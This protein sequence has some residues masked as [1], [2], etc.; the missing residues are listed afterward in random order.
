MLDHAEQLA[1]LLAPVDCIAV[2]G[3]IATRITLGDVKLAGTLRVALVWYRE[4]AA[5][6]NAPRHLCSH[7]LA[8]FATTAASVRQ[9]WMHK[10]ITPKMHVLTCHA[11]PFAVRWGSI[12]L[13]TEQAVESAHAVWNNLFSLNRNIQNDLARLRNVVERFVLHSSRPEVERLKRICPQCTRPI[14][15]RCHPHCDCAKER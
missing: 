6:Y 10:S 4:L 14:A 7:E 15:K 2:N 3:D 1:G 9:M 8:A 12:G 5:L 13:S 11:L